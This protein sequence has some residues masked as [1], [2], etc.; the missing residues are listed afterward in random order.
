MLTRQLEFCGAATAVPISERTCGRFDRMPRKGSWWATTKYGLTAGFPQP[1]A[2]L[3]RSLVSSSAKPL[4][5]PHARCG[6]QEPIA[7]GADNGH[8]MCDALP[9]DASVHRPVALVQAAGGSRNDAG[10]EGSGAWK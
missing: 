5:G 2:R 9:P 1:C 3:G 6:R 10:P 7:T 4:G 8:E